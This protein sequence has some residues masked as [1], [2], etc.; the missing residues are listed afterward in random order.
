M[1]PKELKHFN[2]KN[3]E[4]Q[5]EIIDRAKTYI[6]EKR[7]TLMIVEPEVKIDLSEYIKLFNKGEEEKEKKMME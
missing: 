2:L 4:P 7:K 6:E 1:N 3:R 5:N